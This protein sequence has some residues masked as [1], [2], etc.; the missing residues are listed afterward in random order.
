MNY[1]IRILLLLILFI[2]NEIAFF[3]IDLL[4]LVKSIWTT[5]AIKI[6]FCIYISF[7]C[8]RFI[9]TISLVILAIMNKCQRIVEKMILAF[10]ILYFIF[11]I[12]WILDLIIITINF[13]KFKK[14]WKNCPFVISDL[15]YSLHIRRRCDLYSVN[16]NSRYSYQYICSYNPSKDFKNNLSKKVEPDNII[17]IKSYKIIEDNTL[18]DSFINEYK[19]DGIY[20]CARTNMPKD[21]SFAKHKDCNDSKYRYML[22]FIIL[23]Y[24]RILFIFWPIISALLLPEDN[25]A[26]GP[27]IGNF[28]NVSRKST[29]ETE[30]PKEVVNFER[31]KTINIFI[32]Q[33]N[34]Y[35]LNTN[36][37]NLY[38]QNNNIN[39]D[40][41]NIDENKISFDKN[42]QSGRYINENNSTD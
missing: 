37:K 15:D 35:I 22:A 38:H 41:T 3:I 8:F 13:T 17:C 33:N 30:A 26:N 12:F 39:I 28:L 27:F 11:I 29:I 23:T 25:L 2:I 21:Y 19:K 10:T 42:S 7:I 40:D 1:Y 32:E 4:T 20:Y 24:L 14:Y 31:D 9:Q 36:I 34:E 6:L 16:N 5:K 18:I